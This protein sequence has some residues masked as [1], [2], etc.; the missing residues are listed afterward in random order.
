MDKAFPESLEI[1]DDVGMMHI[2][3]YRC[4]PQKGQGLHMTGA[5]VTK[6]PDVP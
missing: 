3:A 5:L 1:H 6:F 2:S 4:F